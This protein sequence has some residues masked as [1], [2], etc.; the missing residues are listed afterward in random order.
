MIKQ[1]I[2]FVLLFF[3]VQLFITAQDKSGD[4]KF[5]S[6]FLESLKID[7]SVRVRGEL[8]NPANYSNTS[9]D[10]TTDKVFNRVRLGFKAV[11]NDNVNVKIEFQDSRLWG[12]EGSTTSDLNNVDLRQGYLE[13]RELWDKPLTLKAG[14]MAIKGHGNQ[15]LISGL[16]WHNIARSWDGVELKYEPDNYSLLIFGM[17]LREGL[18]FNATANSDDY[19]LG[20][21]YFSWKGIEN[22]N[23]DVFIYN[24]TH[25]DTGGSLEDRKDFTLGLSGKGKTSNFDYSGDLFF[26]TGEQGNSDV[27]AYAAAITGGYTFD[28]DWKPRIGLEFA[29]AS[30]DDNTGDSDIKT[31]DPILPFGHFY[32]GHM[33]F[34]L[35]KNLQSFKI[36]FSVKPIENVSF[37]LDGHMFWLP[38]ETDNFYGIGFSRSNDTGTDKNTIGSEI[39]FYGKWKLFTR[40]YIWAGVSYFAP[41]DFIDDTSG[42]DDGGFWAFFQTNVKF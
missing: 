12:D 10:K 31:F 6:P 3:N 23:L 25:G 14:R 2:I 5:D 35:F 20:G 29:Y 19:F 33:D 16:G 40:V 38:E 4:F 8:K 34:A 15:R 41:G 21:V 36:Q 1:T 32:H 22:H 24:R 39:D 7:G 18:A 37:H 27:S 17:N 42:E 28:I 11:I 9:T 13:L 26:Q 30:G